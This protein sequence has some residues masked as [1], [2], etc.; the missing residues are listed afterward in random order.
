MDKTWEN[1]KK[2]DFGPGFGLFWPKIRSPKF[3]RRF[4]LY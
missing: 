3:F 4:Y 2:T 1:G